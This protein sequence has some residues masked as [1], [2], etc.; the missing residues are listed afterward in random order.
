MNEIGEALGISDPK[1]TPVDLELIEIVE[2]K[3]L[4]T[5]IENINPEQDVKDDYT[6]SRKVIHSLL[7][8][9]Q[10]ALKGIAHLANAS[11]TARTYEVM[12]GMIKT[13]SDNA[14]DLVALQ[15][16]IRELNSDKT[17]KLNQTADTIQNAFYGSPTEALETKEKVIEH[18]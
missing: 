1:D 12:A 5:D 14:K 4:M 8:Q 16:D 13:I 3:R 15:K 11:P 6:Y 10:E 7:E 17:N 9:G 18:E 2:T